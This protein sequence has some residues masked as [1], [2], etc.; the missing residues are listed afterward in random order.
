[1]FKKLIIITTFL[2]ISACDNTNSEINNS[3]LDETQVREIVA[4][5]IDE[6]P[7]ALVASLA[8]FEQQEMQAK[9]EKAKNAVKSNRGEL[10]NPKG[11][12]ILNPDGKNYVVEFFD[13]NC[14]FCK[15]VTPA[16]NQL[17]DE[18]KD[19][20]VVLI[21]LPV[22]GPSSELAAAAGIVVQTKR[23]EKYL[24]FHNKLMEHNGQKDLSI[25]N[26]IARDSDIRDIKFAEEVRKPEV[27][28]IL[29]AN[30]ALASKL[31]ISGTPAFVI[32][33][34]VVPGAI[35]YENMLKI[36]KDNPTE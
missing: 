36:I 20:K 28:S 14:G 23:P 25:I 18:H 24:E 33:D 9:Q 32:N 19:V 12:A 10:V 15:R 5:Y 7:K 6:N 3:G 16:V 31:G 34:A 17:I 22:L 11:A 35:P 30:R 21:E 13:Y 27:T 1:M 4:K 8:K 2:A 29:E 26:Q